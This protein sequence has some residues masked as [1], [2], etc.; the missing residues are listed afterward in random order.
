MYMGCKYMCMQCAFCWTEKGLLDAS[1]DTGDNIFKQQ[2]EE[3][4]DVGKM[5]C[6][7]CSPPLTTQVNICN[8]YLHMYMH[9][10]VYMY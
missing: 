10:H 9:I 5:E 8:M 6:P 7:A 4:V 2:K 3:V 1:V